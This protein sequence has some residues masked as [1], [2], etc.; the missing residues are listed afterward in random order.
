MPH[1]LLLSIASLPHEDLD[2][3]MLATALAE[4][5]IGSSVVNWSEPESWP[6]DADLAVIRTTWDY[7]FRRDE[8]IFAMDNLP[9]PLANPAAIVSWNSHKGYLVELGEAGVPVVP[10][11]LLRGGE[12]PALPTIDAPQIIIKPAISAGAR[13]VG[14]FASDATEAAAHLADLLTRGDALVQPFEPSVNAGE[15]SLMFF[16]GRYSHAV[17]KVPADSDFRVQLRYGGRLLA[18]DASSA[19]LAAATMALSSV[20]DDLLYARVDLVGTPD[21]PLVMELELIEPEIFLPMAEGAADR[22]AGAIAD[23]LG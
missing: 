13:G 11:V 12:P 5:G 16:G 9:M 3:P 23:S 19:E 18:H 22:L 6:A 15:R 20:K 2:S 14:L 17:R 1:V 21:K 10:S 4:R 7:T 8:F